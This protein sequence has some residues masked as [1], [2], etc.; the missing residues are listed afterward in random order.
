MA[1]K[2]KPVSVIK[3]DLGLEPYGDAHRHF[4]KCCQKRM[5]ERYVP[6]KSGQLAKIDL[7][8]IDSECNIHYEEDYA[9]YQYYGMRKDGSREVKK[10]SK[11]GTGPYW[12]QLMI[13][14]E[15][16]LLLKDMQDYFNEKG[17]IK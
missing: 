1:F 13:S 6:Y 9:G 2:M 5:N 10:Y 8:K 4:A 14:A 3:A 11:P 15:K 16:D 17:S 12:D 7:S